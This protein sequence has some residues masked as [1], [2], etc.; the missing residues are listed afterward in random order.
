MRFFRS[1]WLQR[2][3]P[4][5]LL[6]LLSVGSFGFIVQHEGRKH[7]VVIYSPQFLTELYGS[8]QKVQINYA[9]DPVH[10]S[11]VKI[12]TKIISENYIPG[13]SFNPLSEDLLTN[14]NR[15]PPHRIAIL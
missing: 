10:A 8:L 9:L 13:T 3:L 6:V 1:A 12:F 5:L 4:F 7:E 14:P 15:G 2:T 11:A